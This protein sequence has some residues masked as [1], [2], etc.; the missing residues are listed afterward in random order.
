M[1]LTWLIYVPELQITYVTLHLILTNSENVVQR[2]H[3]FF[4]YFF[5]FNNPKRHKHTAKQLQKAIFLQHLDGIS[6]LLEKSFTSRAS[7][8]VIKKETE[9]LISSGVKYCDYLESCLVSA[10]ES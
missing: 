7:F 9:S 1:L 8:A 6:T 3:R 5:P 2:P 4:S 10:Q